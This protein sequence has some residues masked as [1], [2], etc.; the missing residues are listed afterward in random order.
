[1]IPTAPASKESGLG[2]DPCG[3]TTTA[4]HGGPATGIV[5]ERVSRAAPATTT[6]APVASTPTRVTCDTG[7][8][9]R[10]AGA[11]A[12]PSGV[13][14]WT[15]TPSAKPT[16]AGWPSGPVVAASLRQ[17]RR[18]TVTIARPPG[19]TATAWLVDESVSMPQSGSARLPLRRAAA[20]PSRPSGPA[21]WTHVR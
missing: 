21:L 10:T 3:A 17:C 9:A 2:T 11:V 20:G 8:S 14:S 5:I 13:A 7:R 12:V 1:M 6:A 16:H 15:W 19:R 4:G 18:S